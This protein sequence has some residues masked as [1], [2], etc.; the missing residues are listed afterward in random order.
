[1]DDYKGSSSFT[2]ILNVLDSEIE[3]LSRGAIAFNNAQHN[4]EKEFSSNIA[5]QHDI[6]KN[7]QNRLTSIHQARQSI[8]QQYEKMKQNVSS[9]VETGCGLEKDIERLNKQLETHRVRA[10]RS[11]QPPTYPWLS[12]PDS[13]LRADQSNDEILYDEEESESDDETKDVL[14]PF[15][16]PMI[17][18]HS[19]NNNVTSSF[20]TRSSRGQSWLTNKYL[21]LPSSILQ[22]I[23]KFLKPNDIHYSQLSCRKWKRGIDKSGVWKNALSIFFIQENLANELEEKVEVDAATKEHNHFQLGIE[24][25][26]DAY[27]VT[28]ETSNKFDKDCKAKPH[29][30]NITTD[31]KTLRIS[32]CSLNTSRL[33]HEIK[34]CRSI[35]QEHQN[36]TQCRFDKAAMM[37]ALDLG[38]G[39]KKNVNKRDGK[40]YKGF[41]EAGRRNQ[42]SQ[43]TI[44]IR[45]MHERFLNASSRAT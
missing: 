25:A 5:K 30:G 34:F 15:S 42:Q 24:V 2:K 18:P 39:K 17:V 35:I 13:Q 8:T 4:Q 31:K 1:M 12:F 27:V 20:S 3:Q 11:K 23:Y 9:Q 26:H 37:E 6:I 28:V 40:Y 43:T 36:N 44:P 16:V 32:M 38:E 29:E 7:R 21:R 22:C 33:E 10:E 14:I 41:E 45:R 19:G